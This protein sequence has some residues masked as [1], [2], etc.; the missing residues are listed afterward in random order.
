MHSPV[1]V[2]TL[3][4][5]ENGL[6]AVLWEGEHDA[7]SSTARS[8]EGD[9][10][11]ARVLAAAVRQLQEYFAGERHE[12]DLPL[13]PVGTEFQRAAWMQL[14]RIPYGETISYGEQARRMGDVKKSR[15][16][17][18]ANGRNPISIIVPCHRVVGS[19]GALTGFAAGLPAKDW[20]LRH[21]QGTQTLL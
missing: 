14:R 11:A 7:A 18:A 4:A 13:D 1:G 20:L 3:I 5:G 12:F 17:G 16:V 10:T 15:A 21:E 9:P 19:N 8:D 2:L 6:R